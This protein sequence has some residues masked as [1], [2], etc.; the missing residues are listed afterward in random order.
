MGAAAVVALAWCHSLVADDRGRFPLEVKEIHDGD[1]VLAIVRLPWRVSIGPESIRAANYDAW[2]ISRAR[3]AVEVTDDE[4]KAGKA[5]REFLTTLVASGEIYV[6]PQA[7][8]KRDVYG[9]L[10]G[11]FWLRKPG[12]EWI[13]V[14]A[15]MKRGG[16][17]RRSA[18]NHVDQ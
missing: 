15:E 5:A 18:G 1:T 11:E 2:E 17:V 4:I 13:D 14:A 8:G 16:H 9:R 12:G 10:L 3:R 6:T 7:G